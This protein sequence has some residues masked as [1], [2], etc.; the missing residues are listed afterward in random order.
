MNIMKVLIHRMSSN[1]RILKS[2]CKLEN[3]DNR[4]VIRGIAKQRSSLQKFTYN[5]DSGYWFFLSSTQK[6]RRNTKSTYSI[7]LV[8][9]FNS[10]SES[11]ENCTISVDFS[12]I[13]TIRTRQEETIVDSIKIHCTRKNNLLLSTSFPP[14]LHFIH[15]KRKEKR[16]LLIINRFK[17]FRASQR[18]TKNQLWIP[19]IRFSSHYNGATLF[20]FKQPNES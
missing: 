12:S 10:S 15:S 20:C 2:R 18:I 14:F 11:L 19:T 7:S 6:R 17:I 1:Y 13:F 16:R 4:N 3:V 8:Q 5:E 9:I